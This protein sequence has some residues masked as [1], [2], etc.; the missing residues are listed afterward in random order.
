MKILEKMLVFLMN[1]IVE[2]CFYCG[3][4]NRFKRN[5]KINLL[6]LNCSL[7]G[8]PLGFLDL[9]PVFSIIPWLY[10]SKSDFF[11]FFFFN[12]SSGRLQE[13]KQSLSWMRRVPV[14][15]HCGVC[16]E[17]KVWSRSASAWGLHKTLQRWLHGA[18]SSWACNLYE[19][20]VLLHPQRP[21]LNL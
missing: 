4:W 12:M 15:L 9:S 5:R 1:K 11:F 13:A 20:R 21:K 8:L 3:I 2:S 17:E 6:L 16:L 19:S 14:L 18:C 7:V 10:T